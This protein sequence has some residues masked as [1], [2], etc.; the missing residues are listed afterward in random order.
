MDQHDRRRPSNPVRE[1]RKTDDVSRLF[2][3]AVVEV[4]FD[5][6]L[7]LPILLLYGLLVLDGYHCRCTVQ[8]LG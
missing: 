8:F 3:P 5:L 1:I 6:V 4:K 2:L 7:L